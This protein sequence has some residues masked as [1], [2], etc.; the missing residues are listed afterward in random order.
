MLKPGNQSARSTNWKSARAGSN[1]AQS[2]RDSR[3][4]MSE[5]QSA[6]QRALRATSSSAPRRIR[7]KKTPASGRKVTRVR[8]GQFSMAPSPDQPQEVPGDKDHDADQHDEGVVV[9]ISRL[10]PA[11]AHR[12]PD[13]RRRDA[14]GPVAVDR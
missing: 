14:V 13:G 1:A 4:T 6:I 11:G 2:P 10:E 12:Q 8:I 3:K 9:D 5:V 7:M